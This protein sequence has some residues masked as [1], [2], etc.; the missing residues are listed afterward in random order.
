MKKAMDEAVEATTTST[1]YCMTKFP[2]KLPATPM[3]WT[4]VCGL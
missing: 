4:V 3:Q 1:Q 2:L